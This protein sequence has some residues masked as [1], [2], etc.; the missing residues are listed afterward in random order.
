MEKKSIN[1]LEDSITGVFRRYLIPSISGTLVTSIYILA[2]TI[3][4]GWG[5]GELGIAALNLLLPMFSI[6]NGTGILFGVGGSVLMSVS[7]GKGDENSAKKYF[8]AAFSMTIFLGILYSIVGLLFF[9]PLAALLGSNTVLDPYVKAYGMWM[10]GGALSFCA[11]NCLQAFVRND[12]A[13]KKAM[14]GVIAGG[15]TNVVLD[16]LFIFPLQ[17]GMAGAIL[18]SVIGNILTVLILVTHFFKKGSH[19]RFV[20]WKP[21]LVPKIAASGIASFVIELSAGLVT[22]L[23][24]RQLLAYVG[25]NG[26]VVYGIISNSA[27][28]VMSI[29]NGISQAAQPIMAINYG[30]GKRER[31]ELVRKTASRTV[32]AAGVLFTLI[33]LVFPTQISQIFVPLTKELTALAVPAVRIYFISFLAMGFNLLFSCYF[34]SV[35][36]P[37]RALL[38]C[39]LRGFVLNVIF[40]FMLPLIL[41]VT[42]IWLTVVLTEFITAMVGGLLLKKSKNF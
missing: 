4:I 11:A 3:M 13:P 20:P 38:L 41:D 32:L 25:N 27:L 35:L 29:F 19:L 36:L 12:G 15:V 31:V 9:D 10:F 24:N 21:V 30:A 34:Q 37:G 28:V 18:A 1:L 14:I 6:F 42:G 23:F 16:Y 7:L 22:F 26:V 40:V 39:L 5:V 33:G 17:M 8:T 2:D